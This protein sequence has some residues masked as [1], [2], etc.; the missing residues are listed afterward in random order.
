MGGGVATAE[1]TVGGFSFGLKEFKSLR[2]DQLQ[3]APKE[4]AERVSE[5]VPVPGMQ[6][7]RGLRRANIALLLQRPSKAAWGYGPVRLTL[8]PGKLPAWGNWWLP[9]VYNVNMAG[10]VAWVQLLG[11][12]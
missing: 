1:Q 7:S 12:A 8:L 11:Y 9:L 5:P 3:R 2:P 6:R 10:S 4:L